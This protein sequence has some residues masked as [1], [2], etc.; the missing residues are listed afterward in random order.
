[1]SQSRV[2]NKQSTAI[3][4]IQNLALELDE[5]LPDVASVEIEPQG[6]WGEEYLPGVGVH[7]GEEDVQRVIPNK[8]NGGSEIRKAE[9]GT[10]QMQTDCC[11]AT[12]EIR[13]YFYIEALVAQCDGAYADAERIMEA[14]RQ[15]VI[16]KEDV[17]YDGS[18]NYR[19]DQRSSTSHYSRAARFYLLYKYPED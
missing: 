1:M 13:F 12:Y 2:E 15:I 7:I 8:Q 10:Y 4:W 16:R 6:A 3:K 11:H 14:V 17:F 19:S 5:K 9:D 18:A